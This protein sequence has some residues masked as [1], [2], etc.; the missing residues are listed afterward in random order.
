[1]IAFVS[2]SGKNSK[3][4]GSWSMDFAL[5]LFDDF[6]IVRATT[7]LHYLR[8]FRKK[9]NKRLTSISPSKKVFDAAIPPYQKAL[10][11]SAYTCK[12]TYN[13]QP[14]QKRHKNRQRVI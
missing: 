10:D 9:M 7:R 8:I 2:K 14:A 11:K 13:P 4:L 12:L 5:A 1:M 6:S 3:I